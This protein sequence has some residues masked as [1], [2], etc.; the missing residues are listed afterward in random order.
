MPSQ[1]RCSHAS[2][3]RTAVM[4]PLRSS[5]SQLEPVQLCTVVPVDAQTSRVPNTA[6][7][8]APAPAIGCGSSLRHRDPF[9]RSTL[10]GPAAQTSPV[11][12]P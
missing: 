7:W 8:I 4:P 10:P 1:L 2:P 12:W 5:G 6:R 3:G 9:Q 11:F